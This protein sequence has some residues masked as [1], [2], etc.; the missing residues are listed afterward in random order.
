MGSVTGINRCLNQAQ[1]VKAIASRKPASTA[2]NPT[3]LLTGRQSP[4]IRR[5][6]DA[7]RSAEYRYSRPP[8]CL[9]PGLSSTG[10][11]QGNPLRTVRL[12][13]A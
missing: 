5:L 3:P 7:D 8:P 6:S 2:I 10:S 13:Y 4:K 11:A 1:Q 9:F 12:F